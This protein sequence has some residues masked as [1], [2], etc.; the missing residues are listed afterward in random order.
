MERK[1]VKYAGAADMY[2]VSKKLKKK[3]NIIDERATLYEDV[4]TWVEALKGWGATP[5]L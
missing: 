1:V 5:N 2:F 3:H 4:N